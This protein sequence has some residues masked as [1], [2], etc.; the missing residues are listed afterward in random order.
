MSADNAEND[1]LAE[2]LRRAFW[3]PENGGQWSRIAAEVSSAIP[4]VI[5]PGTAEGSQS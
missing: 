1:A 3:N 5:P 4:R 2:V